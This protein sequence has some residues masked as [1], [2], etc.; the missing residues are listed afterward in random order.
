M[1]KYKTVIVSGTGWSAESPTHDFIFK[2]SFIERVLDATA[3]S[4]HHS[5][6]GWV[7][8][9][10]NWQAGCF[11]K[12]SEM[13]KIFFFFFSNWLKSTLNK[14][15]SC[16]NDV[17]TSGLLLYSRV[18]SSGLCCLMGCASSRNALNTSREKRCFCQFTSI[19]SVSFPIHF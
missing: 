14:K 13:Q 16:E 3:T 11:L 19:F 4:V 8:F 9:P 1:L 2:R 7:Q 5:Q 12:N 6:R 18:G 17:F 15:H 10:R